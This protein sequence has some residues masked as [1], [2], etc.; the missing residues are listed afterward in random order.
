MTQLLIYNTALI[1]EFA[2]NSSFIKVKIIDNKVECDN[3]K[4]KEDIESKLSISIKY[5]CFYTSAYDYNLIPIDEY[6]NI[7]KD[8]NITT[9]PIYLKTMDLTEY[10]HYMNK[11][12]NNNNP[13]IYEITKFQ[14]RETLFNTSDECKK[15]ITSSKIYYTAS[16]E[17][18]IER[19]G[20][21]YLRTEFQQ[22]NELMV[23]EPKTKYDDIR[24]TVNYCINN[25]IS[26]VLVG[27][28]NNKIY[29][30][31][32]LTPKTN[33]SFNLSIMENMLIELCKNV[34]IK[35][36]IFII[37]LTTKPIAHED[38]KS[39]LCPILSKRTGTK[40]KDILIVR[41]SE[42]LKVS[43]KYFPDNCE[44]IY[45][46]GNAKA[47]KTKKDK[48]VSNTKIHPQVDVV[49]EQDKNKYKY[50]LSAKSECYDFSLNSV[51]IL[52]PIKVWFS[53]K[54]EPYVHY[55]PV[56]SDYS[57][58]E[59]QL[60]WCK[61][62]DQKC[63]LIAENSVKFYTEYLT[64]KTMLEYMK[65][66]LLN[67]SNIDLTLKTY[68]T[69]I[70]LITIYRD[71]KNHNRLYQK[72][73][74]NYWMN[75]LL[76]NKCDYDIII[77]EQKSGELFNIGKLK[78]IGYDYLVNTLKKTY[79]NI[80]FSDI[81][82]I[83]DTKLFDYY[84][85]TTD[86]LNSL[87]SYG[88]RYKS[89]GKYDKF[90]GALVS[91]TPEIFKELNGYPNNY[92]GWGDEDTNLILRLSMLGKPL[93]ANKRGTIIDI[94]EIDGKKKDLTIKLQELREGRE[95]EN[96]IYE[97]TARY[98]RYKTNGLTNLNYKILYETNFT[99]STGTT[100]HIIVDPEKKESEKLYPEDYN[101]KHR[102]NKEEHK[103]TKYHA[104]DKVKK[105][106]F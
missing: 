56:K 16:T 70:A 93:Y 9:M 33:N 8:H 57:D 98:K 74:Y 36:C 19:Y 54:I 38:N 42:W 68:T 94:E 13:K 37:N 49:N 90:A 72:R 71:D 61:E 52:P 24:T 62:N 78:N 2:H 63:E 77:V 73:L 97:K 43:G 11:N 80:I 85:K 29:I 14:Q 89:S 21:I 79:D 46:E 51:I 103:R 53:N 55:V 17:Y 15:S 5:I 50:I 86:S 101:F 81:D 22:K 12:F 64:K 88:T 60:E 105:I 76:N 40:H 82:I 84:F 96:Y 27:I 58:L 106:L 4:I 47:W 23:E 67:T 100:Y 65:T 92:W 75:K 104:Y 3:N 7:I 25:N 91:C 18:E 26:S 6:W 83:P 34:K 28:K 31:L 48:I 66:I 41:E 99:T 35:D 87:A 102:V 44:N 32:P 10:L 1:Y 45:L 69:K 95:K 39:I 30:Y 59:T 20:Y